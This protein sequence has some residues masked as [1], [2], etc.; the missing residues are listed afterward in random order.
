MQKVPDVE[1]QQDDHLVPPQAIVDAAI[2]NGCKSIAY[3]YNEP[4]VLFLVYFN[5][6]FPQIFYEYVL[7][8]AKLA[9][10]KG[11]KN[12]MITNGDPAHLHHN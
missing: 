8:I 4:T 6:T 9:K 5:P 2:R 11:L 7:E 12:L 3:T 1:D 10:Q